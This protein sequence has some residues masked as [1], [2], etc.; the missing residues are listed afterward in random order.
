LYPPTESISD[1]GKEFKN[2]PTVNFQIEFKS[3]AVF[4]NHPQA[5]VSE[6]HFQWTSGTVMGSTHNEV[7]AA[8]LTIGS[9]LNLVFSAV[10]RSLNYLVIELLTE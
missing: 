9:L 1:G 10:Q 3:T 6:N 4:H 5:T 7:T 2:S 8:S